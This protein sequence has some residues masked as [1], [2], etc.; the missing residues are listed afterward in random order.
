MD[1]AQNWAKFAS[2]SRKHGI[3][4]IIITNGFRLLQYCLDQHSR[5]CR[6]KI[7]NRPYEHKYSVVSNKLHPKL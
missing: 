5:I 4:E 3:I 1:I 6:P 7:R 2:N